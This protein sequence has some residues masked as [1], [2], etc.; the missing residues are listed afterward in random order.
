LL[1]AL[2]SDDPAAPDSAISNVSP[3][4]DVAHFSV[5]SDVV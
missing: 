3:A 2:T 1:S 4:A 5:G